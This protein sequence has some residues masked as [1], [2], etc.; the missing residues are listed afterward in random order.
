MQ[1]GVYIGCMH[2]R[3]R[4]GSIALSGFNLVICSFN[5]ARNIIVITECG[6]KLKPLR[7]RCHIRDADSSFQKLSDRTIFRISK[8]AEIRGAS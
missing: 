7:E 5:S 2:V 4:R 1:I 3:E 8:M 6:K